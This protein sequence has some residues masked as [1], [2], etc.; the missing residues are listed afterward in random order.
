MHPSALLELLAST[1]W[2]TINRSARNRIQYGE[3]EITSVNLNALASSPDQTV[4]VE[5]TRVDEATKGCDFE[6]WIGSD[7]LGWARYAIQAKKISLPTSSY[8]KL[9]HKVGSSLQVD[10]LDSYAV[11]NRAAPLYCFYNYSTKDHGWNC[12]LPKESEQLGCSVT[13]S[14][15]VRAHLSIRGARSFQAIHANKATLP[16]RCLVRCPLIAGF[17]A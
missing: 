17:P 10:V 6:F 4:V 7:H 12:N 8:S 5:D 9:G 11:A 2:R 1:T 3:D 14:S 16:W 15:V 13:P